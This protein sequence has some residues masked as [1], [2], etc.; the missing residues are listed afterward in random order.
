MHN[1][2]ALMSFGA[3]EASVIVAVQ[4]HSSMINIV[5]KPT[6][7]TAC[8]TDMES[9]SEDWDMQAAMSLT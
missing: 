5:D 8:K 3:M 4:V 7:R 9:T 2:F 1:D 6:N